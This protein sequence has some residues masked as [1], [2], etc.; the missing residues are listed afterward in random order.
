MKDLSHQAEI[1][2]RAEVWKFS[3]K[4]PWGTSATTATTSRF[5]RGRR[6]L[7]H[8]PPDRGS[9]SSGDG[10]GRDGFV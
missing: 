7:Y 8:M 4:I 10:P 5:Y 1:D 9:F 6:R 2:D 3:K